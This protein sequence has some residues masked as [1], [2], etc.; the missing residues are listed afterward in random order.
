ME[1]VSAAAHKRNKML[2]QNLTQFC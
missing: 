1:S 2:I